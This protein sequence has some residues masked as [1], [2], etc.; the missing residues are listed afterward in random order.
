MNKRTLIASLIAVSILCLPAMASAGP[1]VAKLKGPAAQ[2][3]QYGAIFEEVLAEGDA[4]VADLL[5]LLEGPEALAAKVT[6]MNL[7]GEL[8]AKDALEALAGILETS[9][10]ASLIVNAARAMGEIGGNRAFKLLA[11]ALDGANANRQADSATVKKA[12]IL[13]LGLTG[14]KKAVNLLLAELDDYNN[15]EIVRIYA[16]GSLG[17]LGSDAGLDTATAGLDSADP[18]VRLASLR[19]LGLIASAGSEAALDELAGPGS[20]FVVRNAARL[21]L[22]QVKAARMGNG[23]KVGF[24]KDNLLG[25]PRASELVAWGTRELARTASKDAKDALK[26]M[27]GKQ[28]PEYSALRRAA[29]IKG[30]Q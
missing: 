20:K 25:N 4:A 16:A 7:L 30:R 2:T 12:A 23:E 8:K 27:A 10:N 17:L 18:S 6:A 13:G 28:G 3:D 5:A 15:D 26:E 9:D 1:A 11:D 29:R 14:D 24:L 21:A 19:A 22:V